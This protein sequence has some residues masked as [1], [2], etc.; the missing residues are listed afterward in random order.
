M[1]RLLRRLLVGIGVLVAAL[2]VAV[3]FS[4]NR[5]GA[6]VHVTPHFAGTCAPLPLPASAEDIRIDR[7]G[8]L[9]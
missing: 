9:A 1:A 5:I 6:F 4:L 7:S 8:A 3:L 2:V